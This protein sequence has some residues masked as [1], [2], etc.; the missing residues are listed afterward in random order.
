VSDED[1]E[2]GR[3]SAKTSQTASPYMW[4]MSG[5]EGH[6]SSPLRLANGGGLDG[7]DRRKEMGEVDGDVPIYAT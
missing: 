3:C 2:C 6:G 4:A 1:S 7:L 5:L